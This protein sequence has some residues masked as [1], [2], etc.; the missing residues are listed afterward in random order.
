MDLVIYNG[1]ILTM[2]EKSAKAV[3]VDYGRIRGFE[4]VQA[5]E[6]IDLEGRTLIP[7]FIDCHCHFIGMGL[8][9]YNVDLS[10]VKS[11]EEAVKKLEERAAK[12]EKD[13][14]V[15]GHSWDE[16][17]WSEKRYLAP[18]DLS[19]IE[20]PVCAAR[21]DGHMAVLN[22]KAQEKL[23]VKK[24]Y[25]YEDEL[26][27][28]RTYTPRD[29]ERA[30]KSAVELAHREGV[31]SIHDNPSDVMS[32]FQYQSAKKAGLRIYVNLPASVVDSLNQI[33]LRTGFGN[34]WVRFGGIK[35]F[36]DGSIGAKTAAM[37]FNFRNENNKGLLVYED[38][39]L[40][41]ILKKAHPNQTAI[42]AIGDRAI[43]QVLDCSPPGER[44]RIEHAELVRDDQIPLIKRLGLILSMQPNFLQWSYPGGLYDDRFGSGMDNRFQTLK[45][46]GIFIVL[47]SDCM[48][49]SPLYGI[50]QVV[51]AP[52]E[53]QR[54][55]VM[56][57][58][59]MYTR[60]GAYASFEEDIKGT[61]ERGKLADFVVLSSDP[62]EEDISKIEVD[63][64]IVD[65]TVVYNRV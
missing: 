30:F 45:K 1:T 29:T 35:I 17:F 28:L 37:S 39:A 32:F 6:E 11:V 44:N 54:L 34:E 21:V 65:G 18:E 19:G 63:M 64:T 4:K 7:G 2:T 53:E 43:Q 55:S 5:Q 59:A 14:W 57:A 36:T 8:S 40:K 46:A 58:L 22:E 3:S 33:K 49:F 20:N 24:G 31:T 60:N 23:G 38:Y 10:Q 41:E 47:G 12:T 15:V 61:I 42:H 51:N 13:Q 25:L 56:D 48:P 52:F 50:N 62:R 16:S 27:E 9:L 26:F